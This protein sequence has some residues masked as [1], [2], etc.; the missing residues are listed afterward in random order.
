MMAQREEWGEPTMVE[1]K[2][3]TVLELLEKDLQ[4]AIQEFGPDDPHV[5]AMKKQL[6]EMRGGSATKPVHFAGRL[7]TKPKPPDR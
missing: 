6:D 4:W 2:A 5:K 1:F 7:G 3:P